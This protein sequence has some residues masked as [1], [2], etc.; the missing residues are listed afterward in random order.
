[1]WEFGYYRPLDLFSIR[2]FFLALS[3][4]STPIFFSL[5]KFIWKLKAPSKV[6]AFAWLLA[7]KRVNTNNLLQMRRTFKAFSLDHCTLC[8]GNRE[9]IDHLL[10]IVWWLEFWHIFLHCSMT[11][12]FFI[13]FYFFFDRKQQIYTLKE[14]KYKR[15][16]RNPPTKDKTKQHNKRTRNYT[17]KTT[18]KLSWLDHPIGTTHC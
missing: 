13:F 4:Q 7:N 17:M 6:K 2:S 12:E 11:L 16:M 3:N 9:S 15:K 10:Y 14:K 18:N 1:M 8:M 5:T